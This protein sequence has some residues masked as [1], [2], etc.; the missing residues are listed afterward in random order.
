MILFNKVNSDK[1]ISVDYDT[2]Y[3]LQLKGFIPYSREKDCVYFRRSEDLEDA[4]KEIGN[5]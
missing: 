2:S 4:L 1:Y 3:L 5:E